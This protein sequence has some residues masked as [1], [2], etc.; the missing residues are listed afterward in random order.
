M[1]KANILIVE[2]EY[3]TALDIKTKLIIKSHYDF[4]IVASGEEAVKIASLEK[5]DLIIMDIKLQGELDGIE[6]AK[7]ILKK[8]NVPI[9]F[10]SGNSDL[11]KSKRLRDMK[12]FGIL[13]KP[14]YDHEL[15][16][17]VDRINKMKADKN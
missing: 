5:F 3:I 13:H 14:I 15:D 2:D 12:P 16:E 6:A 11:F 17:F 1:E 7:L 9:L 8:Q 4:H 10:I